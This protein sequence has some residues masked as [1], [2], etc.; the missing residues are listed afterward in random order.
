MT[1]VAR[2][3]SGVPIRVPAE[4][5]EH[6][7]QNHPEMAGYLYDLIAAIESPDEV[8]AGTNGAQIAIKKVEPGKMLAVVYREISREDGFVIPPS[9]PES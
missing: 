9:L 2:S 5:W 8:R 7:S 3:Y 6:I 4:R 1:H